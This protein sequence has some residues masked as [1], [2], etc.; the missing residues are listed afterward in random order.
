MRKEKKKKHKIRIEKM[1]KKDKLNP[2][3]KKDFEKLIEKASLHNPK[4]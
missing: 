3:H 2:T 4:E 1:D